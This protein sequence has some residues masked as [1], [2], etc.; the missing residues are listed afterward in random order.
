LILFCGVGFFVASS[1]ISSLWQVCWEV[2]RKNKPEEAITASVPSTSSLSGLA[3]SEA[4]QDSVKP[5][6]MGTDLVE[7]SPGPVGNPPEPIEERPLENP[8]GPVDYH[9][10]AAQGPLEPREKLAGRSEGDSLI[11]NPDL[12][13]PDTDRSESPQKTPQSAEPPTETPIR[14]TTTKGHPDDLTSEAGPERDRVR[15]ILSK[16]W[17]LI[18]SAWTELDKLSLSEQKFMDLLPAINL[19]CTIWS[20]LAVEFTIR[21]NN[22]TEVHTIQSVGQLIPFVIGVVGMLKLLRD[23]SVLVTERWIYRVV[24]VRVL[25]LTSCHFVSNCV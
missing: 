14:D 12:P 15:V 8:A 19:I 3:V 7:R 4:K 25:Q 5:A 6:T 20:I 9:H 2:Q 21:W 16:F 22:I 23:I 11:T 13:T 17:V 1:A 18:S 10:G 24:V